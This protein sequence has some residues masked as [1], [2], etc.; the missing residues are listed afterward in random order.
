MFAIILYGFRLNLLELTRTDVV[1]SITTMVLFFVQK[2]SH[3]GLKIYGDHLWT[4]RD[5]IRF[6]RRPEEPRGSD[7][8]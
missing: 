8:P 2:S 3:N 6:E 4:R 5:P 1:F 7:K